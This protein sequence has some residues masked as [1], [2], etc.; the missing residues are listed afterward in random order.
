MAVFLISKR[1]I[2]FK[3][4]TF[5]SNRYYLRWWRARNLYGS[6][7]P[8]TTGGFELRISCTRSSLNSNSNEFKKI[9]KSLLHS[10]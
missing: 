10:S 9:I 6:Q 3:K 2:P 8:V 1:V 5:V 4:K 7:I